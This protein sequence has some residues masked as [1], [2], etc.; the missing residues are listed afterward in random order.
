[1]A[2]VAV[3]L[4]ELDSCTSRPTVGTDGLLSTPRNSLAVR[5]IQQAVT[6]NVDLRSWQDGIWRVQERF[7]IPKGS[8]LNILT[9]A[10]SVDLG[11]SFDSVE[12][13]DRKSVV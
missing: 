6:P 12:S 9:S 13:G 1:M 5:G 10:V 4:M 11:E 8:Y 2:S 7:R 3:D